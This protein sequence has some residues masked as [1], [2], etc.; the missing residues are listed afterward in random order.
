M[1][2][3]HPFYWEVL[4]VV[5]LQIFLLIPLFL[6]PDPITTLS[7]C[8]LLQTFDFSSLSPLTYITKLRLNRQDVYESNLRS[9][10]YVK[11]SWSLP[12]HSPPF[13]LSPSFCIAA[14][15]I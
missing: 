7:A 15:H 12:L 8:L 4:S 10:Q 9:L 11:L 2:W 1:H 3:G 5:Y 13:F 6:H 14:P